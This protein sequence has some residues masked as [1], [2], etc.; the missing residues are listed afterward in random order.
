MKKILAF[1]VSSLL[2]LAGLSLSAQTPPYH[3]LTHKSND[4]FI[5]EASDASQTIIVGASSLPDLISNY[6]EFEE[7]FSAISAVQSQAFLNYLGVENALRIEYQEAGYGQ[8]EARLTS[9]VTDLDRIFTGGSPDEVSEQIE[10]FLVGEG[11]NEWA[12]IQ[13]A[14]NRRSPASITDGNPAAATASVAKSTFAQTLDD[15]QDVLNVLSGEEPSGSGVDLGI[16]LSSGSFT[17]TLPDGREVEGKNTDLAIP[18]KHKIN[19]R[20]S[21]ALNLPL[22]YM[23]TEGAEIFTVGLN[24]ALPYAAIPVSKEKNVS[25]KI[26]PVGGVL[27]RGSYD[28]ASG[29]A[30]YHLGASSA[31]TFKVGP[32]SLLTIGNQIGFY[33]SFEVAFDKVKVD[34][35]ISQQILKN[36]LRYHYLFGANKRWV[37][38]ALYVNTAF[39]SDAAVSNYHT[40]GGGIAY[41]FTRKITIGLHGNYD[42]GDN[43]KLWNIG[44][45]SVWKF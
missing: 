18:Y 3:H 30:L 1:I 7:A 11:S 8:Y 4:P 14:I 42:L 41:R 20:L 16:G 19:E 28:F 37:V 12:K 27:L 6:I 5:L 25:W 23:E 38:N 9:S 13:Q 22:G 2:A 33:E 36:G 39:L 31:V 21:L 34:P 24:L 44:I 29:A 45:G 40:F 32:S 15:I 26:A 43:Y 17:V 35:N 10:D